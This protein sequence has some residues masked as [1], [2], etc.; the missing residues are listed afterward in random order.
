MSRYCSKAPGG[1]GTSTWA[2]L[3]PF[4]VPTAFHEMCR[5]EYVMLM[6]WK[7]AAAGEI[8]YNKCPPNA[9]GEGQDCLQAPTPV[10]LAVPFWVSSLF[11]PPA[12][13]VE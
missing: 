8:I 13:G 3:S 6:T 12:R 11:D 4:V 10:I 1:A 2:W 5:D 7:K 9:S